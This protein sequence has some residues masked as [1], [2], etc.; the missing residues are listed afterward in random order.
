MRIFVTGA[1]GYIG[2]SVA[3]ALLEAGHDV[4]G[5]A[6]SDKAVKTL[7]QRGIRPFQGTLANP[8][9]VTAAA[10][11]A[12]AIIHTAFDWTPDGPLADEAF[13][14]ALL[15]ALGGRNKTFVYTSGVWVMGNT[16][17]GAD[18]DTPPAAPP[19]VAWRVA[20]ERKVMQAA[21]RGVRSVVIRPAMVYGRGGGSVAGFLKSARENGAAVYVGTGENHWTF[22][23]VDDLADLYLLALNA[24]PGSLF[25]GASGSPHRVKEVAEAAGWA[26]GAKGHTRT[27][28]VDEAFPVLG[29]AVQGLI[30]DQR[31]SGA[32]A[33]RVLGWKPHAPSV[34]EEVRHG[35]YTA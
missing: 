32:R 20:V 3:R 27:W 10:A 33:E 9:A 8:E 13:I 34:I 17:K 7:G 12:D 4:I 28:P 16:P 29:P 31:I 24:E 22:V 35:S 11:E 14:R 19:V 6:R 1:T 26:A 2:S 25:I 23:H 18:E 5:L 21:E 30:L 15:T